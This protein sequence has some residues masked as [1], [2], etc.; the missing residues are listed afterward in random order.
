MRFFSKRAPW[1]LVGLALGTVASAQVPQLVNGHPYLPDATLLANHGLP[2]AYIVQP[3]PTPITIPRREPLPSEK[4]AIERAN[5]LLAN[6][7]A[8]AIF[9]LD[10]INVV[11][12]GYKSPASE[13]SIFTSA[14]MGKTVTT[15]AVGKA[16]CAG[17]MKL[18]DRAGDILPE[19]DKTYLGTATVRDLLRMSS[20]TAKANNPGN[21][22]TGNIFSP[23]EFKEWGTGNIDLL[24]VIANPKVSK[25]EKGL[26]S[27][28][29][30]GEAFAYKNTDPIALGI[31]INRVTGMSYSKWVQQEIFDPMGA[32]G[33]GWISQNRKHQALAYAGVQL[34]MEDWIRFAWWVKQ[35]S[36][37]QDCFGD[38]VRDASRTQIATGHKGN[39][40]YGY[41]MWTGNT[42]A[43]DTAWA[44][45]WGGQRIGWSYKGNRMIVVFSNNEDWMAD[46]SRLYREWKEIDPK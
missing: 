33:S 46:V 7:S 30:P 32:A 23:D 11:F 26:L 17:K 15:M 19:L 20:G 38:F 36:L 3:S 24:H 28:F 21:A 14:S 16:I 8:K 18:T 5:F 34:R 9:L 42:D 29:R 43:P 10:G 27:D 31:M 6:R 22:F 35:A 39:T 40:G 12:A 25:A 44:V 45:G 13:K 41:L 2:W 37:Q 1:F 4:S